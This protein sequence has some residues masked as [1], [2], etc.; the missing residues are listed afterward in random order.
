MLSQ[1][2]LYLYWRMRFA[3]NW[4]LSFVMMNS[5]KRKSTSPSCPLFSPP[6]F[7][8]T[9][10]GMPL[11]YNHTILNEINAGGHKKKCRSPRLLTPSQVVC[12]LVC[13]FSFWSSLFYCPH[14]LLSKL[15]FPVEIR[16]FSCL[17]TVVLEPRSAASWKL[18]FCSC[19][20]LLLLV[21]T[22]ICTLLPVLAI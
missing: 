21:W 18:E 3:L 10:S 4:D 16:I 15:I 7:S 22:W 13:P 5:Q 1:W 8:R 20:S 12:L 2:S 17:P 6:A 9:R 19:V 14:W 11:I